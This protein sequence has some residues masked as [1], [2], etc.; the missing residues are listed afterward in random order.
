MHVKL[1]DPIGVIGVMAEESQ[2]K[3]SQVK[4]NSKTDGETTASGIFLAAAAISTG[5]RHAAVAVLSGRLSSSR[6]VSG[7]RMMSYRCSDSTRASGTDRSGG[8]HS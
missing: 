4:S 1:R 3:S 6:V 2:V 7:V 8:G 5:D